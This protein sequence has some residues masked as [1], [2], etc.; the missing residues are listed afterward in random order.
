[1]NLELKNFKHSSRTSIKGCRLTNK[2][3]IVIL[4]MEGP[5]SLVFL[6]D[7]LAN[8]RYGEAK[9]VLNQEFVVTTDGSYRSTLVKRA[10]KGFGAYFNIF[11]GHL[12]SNFGST[13][14]CLHSSSS[15]KYNS[16]IYYYRCAPA[17]YTLTCAG[18]ARYAELIR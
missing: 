4:L 12:G 18:I 15:K 1:M 2:D 10:Q 11:Y 14:K 17:M 13:H 9:Y 6:R 5:K 16:P 3:A 7:E 8:W